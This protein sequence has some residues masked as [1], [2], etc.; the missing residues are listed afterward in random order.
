MAILYTVNLSSRTQLGISEIKERI[1][2]QPHIYYEFLAQLFIR[3]ADSIFIIV[4]IQLINGAYVLI[5]KRKNI[6]ATSSKF[7]KCL[8]PFPS[9]VSTMLQ[10]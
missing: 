7:F 9:T 10:T 4:K 5:D 3:V 8:V 6:F 2:K 1:F